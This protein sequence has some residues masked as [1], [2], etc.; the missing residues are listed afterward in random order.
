M[1]GFIKGSQKPIKVRIIDKVSEVIK[2]ISIIFF[3]NNQNLVIGSHLY[4]YTKK[5]RTSSVD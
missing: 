4:F 1:S 2:K 5:I 3:W